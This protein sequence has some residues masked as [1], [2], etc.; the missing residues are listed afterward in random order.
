[1]KWRD[2]AGLTVAVL[3]LLG[4]GSQPVARWITKRT[5]SQFVSA[6][7][8]LHGSTHWDPARHAWTFYD[9]KIVADGGESIQAA[10][11]TIRINSKEFFQR[12]LVIESAQVDGIVIRV[13]REQPVHS[14]DS[15]QMAL[16]LPAFSSDAW[17][18]ST[19]NQ[20]KSD[21]LSAAR[22]REQ[23]RKELQLD[24]E[25]LHK[26]CFEMETASSSNP[27]RGR[28]EIQ[29]VQREIANLRQALAEERIRVRETDRELEHATKGLREGW[30]EEV[31]RSIAQ[32]LPEQ[33]RL[34][35]Q[36]AE[37]SIA[38]Y[39]E[40]RRAL[41]AYATATAKP[42]KELQSDNRGT[43]IPI[44]G[45]ARNYLRIRTANLSGLM[46]IGDRTPVRFQASIEGWGDQWGAINPKSDW[47]FELASSAYSPIIQT[48]VERADD[49]EGWIVTWREDADSQ[50]ECLGH[51]LATAQGDL[52]EISIPVDALVSTDPSAA[53]VFGG[54]TD[55][56][57]CWKSV[58]HGYQGRELVAS[59]PVT[60]TDSEGV[61]GG[62]RCPAPQIHPDTLT[63][64]AQAWDKTLENYAARV[65]D[66]MESRIGGL[67]IAMEQ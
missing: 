57:T 22:Y 58:L 38:E 24:L 60:P 51:L 23:R 8:D 64:M 18:D 32:S 20:H 36:I 42:L 25:R 59:L 7:A 45:I 1:M 31:A 12:N 47:R 39:W 29:E 35:Q 62:W 50:H 49:G 14:P 3:A 28:G 63:V 21:V 54:A 44:A 65:C 6:E 26:R 10:R 55:W 61:A 30:R 48:H 43:E 40:S 66:R 13:P 53:M 19:L 67:W 34:I 9:L 52:L 17:M 27:L 41:L 4:I 46:Q 16:P 56:Q 37:Q 11:S 15:L 2:T 33:S 5:V